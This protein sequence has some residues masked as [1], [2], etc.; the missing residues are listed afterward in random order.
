MWILSALAK[1]SRIQIPIC[2]SGPNENNI[3]E[4]PSVVGRVQGKQGLIDVFRWV[5]KAHTQCGG[6]GPYLQSA[7]GHKA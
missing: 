4:G 6:L 3:E 7:Q 5:R 2:G 1:A